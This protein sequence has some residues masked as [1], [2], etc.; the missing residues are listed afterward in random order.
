VKI[1]TVYILGVPSLN[2]SHITVLG[3]HVVFL[4]F[5]RWMWDWYLKY[6]HLHPSSCV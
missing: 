5:P 6:I 1:V 4:R 3:L 2:V